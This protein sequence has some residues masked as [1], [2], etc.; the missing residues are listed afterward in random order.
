[1]PMHVGDNHDRGGNDTQVQFFDQGS[2]M[3]RVWDSGIIQRAEPD[4]DRWLADLVAMDTD[5]ARSQAQRG[6][7]E[8][9]ATESLLAAKQAYQDPA[10]GRPIKSGQKLGD[11]YQKAS[12]PVV[13]QRLYQAVRGWRWCST[14]FSRSD[15]RVSAP[16]W[17]PR[18]TL[19]TALSVELCYGCPDGPPA[20]EKEKRRTND[21]RLTFRWSDTMLSVCAV[22]LATIA[23]SAQQ[24][25][26]L[27]AAWKQ[28]F[29][30][31]A[32]AVETGHSIQAEA[33]LAEVVEEAEKLGRDDLRLAEPLETL[34]IFYMRQIAEAIYRGRA[35]VRAVRWRSERKRWGRI[36]PR[37]P[38]RSRA[39]P[40][41]R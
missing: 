25:P 23:I 40:C 20:A 30:A 36:I 21:S 34:A 22:W 5:R 33:L 4:Q 38:R 6:I 35:F 26:E 12:L 7:V 19:A 16:T 1:M 3:H 24:S 17:V 2:N 8:E 32:K 14:T 28:K 18:V 29:E 39:S 10:T 37:W 11:A 41:V 9:W 13:K 31:A 15:S 27:P